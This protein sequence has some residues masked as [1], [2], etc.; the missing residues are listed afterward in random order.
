MA[1]DANSE[2]YYSNVSSITT[3]F[4]V[5]P[6]YDDF[7]QSKNYYRLLFKP[8]FPVQSRELTQIQSMLQDQIQKFGQHVFK[9][10]SMVLGGK[11]YIDTRAH[12]VKINDKDVNGNDVDV[13]LFKNQIVTGQTTG[14][15]AFVNLVLDGNESSGNTKTLYV[16]YLTGNP[17]TDE[18]YFTSNEPLVSNVG[19]A[20]VGNNSPVGY[21]STFTIQEGLR[22]AKQHFVYHTKQTIVI[23][24][25]DIRPTCK[26]GF[27]LVESIVDA[28]QDSSLLDPALESSNYAAPG[29]DRFKITPILTRLDINDVAGFPDYVNL[30]EIRNG[31]VT[32][33]NERPTYNVIR[34]EIAKRT[35]DESGDYYVQGFNVVV[36]EHLDNGTN[37]GYL[38]LDKGGDFSKLSV[39][40]EPGTA[41]VKGY[42]VNKL[43]TEFITTDK[44]TNFGN[45]SSQIVSTAIGSYVVVDEAV[46]A[47]NVNTGQVIDLYDTAQNR[48]SSGGS[49]NAGQTG[50]KIGSARVLS[51]SPNDGRVGTSTGTLKLHL[52]DIQ[53]LGT[54]AF[55][56]VKSVYSNNT[57][58]ADIGA[59]IVLSTSNTATIY[60]T[61]RPL[62]YPTG[63]HHTKNIR[64]VDESVDTSFHFKKTSDISIASD[65]TF[66]VSSSVANE[67]FPYGTG[68]VSSSDVQDI[69]LT[70]NAPVNLSLPGSALSGASTNTITGD[71]STRFTRL[72]V[73]DRIVIS[74]DTVNTYT[75]TGIASDSSMTVDKTLPSVFSGN[76]FT[77]VY[78]AGDMIDLRSKG[79]TA[80]VTRTV[81][82]TSSSLSV[83]LNETFGSTVSATVTY[84]LAKTSA[85]EI[86]KILKPNRYVIIDCSTAGTT[87]PFGLGFSDI[88]RI[89]SIRKSTTAFTSATD[90]TDVTNSFLMDNGQR[91]DC[92][93]NGRI[94][95]T[96]TLTS[97]D[98]LLVSLDYFQPDYTLGAGY[99]SVDSYPINDVNPTSTEISTVGVPVFVSN[100]TDNSFDL[101]NYL[102][103]RPIFTNTATDSTVIAG[104]TTNPTTS[105]TLQYDST[106]LKLP[107]DSQPATFSF[108]YYWAR[109]DVVAVD[110]YGNFTV[111]QGVASS[112]PITPACPDKLMS[113]AKLYISPYPSVSPEYARQLGRNDMACHTSKTAQVRFTMKDIGTLKQRVDNIEN[114][115]SLSLLEKNAL[116]MKILD[117]N[118][119]DRFKNG[120]FVDSFTSF[121]TSDISNPDHHI[122]YDPQEGSIRPLSETHAI[123]YNLVSNTNIV[124]TQNILMLPYTEVVASEQPYATTIMNVETNVYRFVGNLY[125]DPDSDYWVNTNRLAAQTYSFGSTLSDVTPYSIVYGSWQTTVT[126]ITKSDPTLVSSSTTS[127]TSTVGSS[128]TKNYI[129]S[130]AGPASIGGAGAVGPGLAADAVVSDINSLIAL[131]GA[132][133]PVTLV[134]NVMGGNQ[135]LR[136][137]APLS[138]QFSN[139]NTLGDVLSNANALKAL[140]NFQISI[141]TTAGSTTAT[142]TTNT[143]STITTTGTQATRGFTETFQSLQTS[144]QSIGDKV[145]TVAPI[146]DIRPQ[147]IAFEAL[148]VKSGTKHY[149]YFDG[150][151]MTSFVTPA[152]IISLPNSPGNNIFGTLISPDGKEGDSLYSDANGVICGY[153][154]LPSDASKTFRTGTKEVI[155]TDSPTNE[156]D[157]TSYAKAYFVAQGITQTVQETI[158]STG[159][160]VTTTK[161]GVQTQPIV[162]SNTTNNYITTS[163]TTSNTGPM[164]TGVLRDVV[165]CMAYSF[166]LNTPTGE[167]GTFLSSVDVY[168]AAK[169]P[170]LGV[171]FEVRAMDN[172]GNITKTQV[173]YSEVWLSSSDVNV[174]DDSSVATNVKFKNPI[175]LQNNQEYAFVIHTVGINPNYYVYVSVLGQSDIIIQ[176]PINN[177]PLTGTLYIT[178][179]N[180]DWNPIMRTD[181]KIRFNRAKFTTGVVGQ[182]VIGNQQRDYV[183]IPLTPASGANVAWFGERVLGNDKLVISTPSGGT[184]S[185]GDYLIGGTTSTN[186]KIVA[187]NGSEYEME[188]GGYEEG[189]SLIVRRANGLLTSVT[190][191]VVTKKCA[192]GKIYTIKS[193]NNPDKKTFE[194]N[195]IVVV[196]DESN[197]QFSANSKIRGVMSGNTVNTTSLSKFVYSTV[198]FEPSQLNFRETGLNFSM[199]TTSNTGSVGTYLPIVPSNPVDFNDEKAVFSRTTELASFNGTPSN[200][201]LIEMSTTSDYLSPIVDLNR[202]YTV[203]VHNLI[204]SNTTYELLPYGGMLT[205][206][207]I[208]QVVTLAD[209]Q[210]AEDL[211][212]YITAYRAPTSNS[213]IK[214]YARISNAEDME[215]IYSRNW[216]ELETSGSGTYSSLTNRKNFIEYQYAFPESYMTGKNDQNIPIVEYKNSSNTVFQGF[217]QYQIKIGLQSDNSA[218]FPRVADLRAI[219][220]QV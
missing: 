121:M 55:S 69:F 146:A 62:L 119:L 37:G 22:F 177:R 105:I 4:N 19:T 126:G 74:G 198:Q 104:A 35:Y 81:T 30:F 186:T 89:N 57:G 96:I 47:W 178:N 82:A 23:D 113:L 208:S 165:S 156:P 28:T 191:S 106:G 154:R 72:N 77:K 149:V 170:T 184:I 64:A 59:D 185:T 132:S 1:V 14:I 199:A 50:K 6:Y 73:Y 175:F 10:G 120:I 138:S 122:C 148:G 58:T 87:G 61:F 95:P 130:F 214:V 217:R 205:N 103:F 111:I 79:V 90:G 32:D 114:Y 128:T 41:Y 134:G 123:G 109:R 143:Y 131:Y 31:I 18:V 218:I 39:Q 200:R 65:G 92:Y 203:Y 112:A 125:L 83:S 206:K 188:D 162:Y 169:D 66:T 196:I 197:G 171:W 16:S 150:Q 124:K 107:A 85:R 142:K 137:G 3:N 27:E 157:A 202:T 219:A 145:I 141:S 167:E 204:N 160:V 209:G 98:K 2:F 67:I 164:S 183:Q 24:R 193:K 173:P 54:N 129:I 17:D 161:N 76:T 210:D 78:Y 139:I 49:S 26:V 51:V 168:F 36:E 207:Y 195:S 215:S 172:A 212:V 153:L 5:N 21:G 136:N 163:V 99:F 108:S 93:V 116:D 43:V 213:E 9:E 189:E 97:S 152:K 12:Y 15:K 46:G 216:I 13:S 25:Y 180:T 176:T 33:I 135:T 190:T 151:L 181:L 155:V 20:I 86:K 147:T 8:G 56:T 91:D 115:V 71:A 40:V 53:M 140:N 127:S 29:A 45:V 166:K 80:G 179:N 7:E 42:E 194:A 70:L 94:M 174:S 118:G 48:I 60:D 100:V 220:L 117:A 158:I 34:D 102:D 52:F 38:T 75:I 101:R 63:S 68:S 110:S 192:S 201:V 187:I 159:K 211:Q 182:A 84:T 144:T 88:Y 44:S 11:H 133:T